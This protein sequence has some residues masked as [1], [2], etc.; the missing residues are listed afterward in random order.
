VPDILPGFE[1]G[2]S[3]NRYR[4]LSTG[5]Y[6]ARSDIMDLLETQTSGLERRLG[7][8]T[9]AMQEGSLAPGYFADQVRTELRRA[10]L[11]NIALGSG[12]WERISQQQYGKAGQRLREDYARISDLARGIQDGTVSLPQALN[13][14]AGYAGNARLGYWEASRDAARQTGRTYEERRL[15]G[16]SE[17]CDDCVSYAEQSWQPLGVLNPPGVGSVCSTHCRCTLERR[18]VTA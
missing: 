15:L 3:S 7:A 18:E 16:T 10:H 2:R 6:V 14:V 11:Q 12:G 17:H 13:R 5:R 1:Y 9:Q 4:D 8:L